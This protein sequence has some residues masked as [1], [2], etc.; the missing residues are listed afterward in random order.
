MIYLGSVAVLRAIV[1]ITV[2]CV[3]QLYMYY[4]VV[5][6]IMVHSCL[7][8]VRIFFHLD[9]F[10]CNHEPEPCE[11]GATCIDDGR[12]GYTCNCSSGYG[13]RNCSILCDMVY[14]PV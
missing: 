1:A 2:K 11:N 12:G 9:L 4:F 6:Y 3:S 7:L 8:N 14:I 10:P 13:G 5:I